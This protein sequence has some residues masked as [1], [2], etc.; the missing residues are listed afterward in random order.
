M[1]NYNLGRDIQEMK[2]ALKRIESV[3]GTGRS[4]QG[5]DSQTCVIRNVD[6][7]IDIHNVRTE[8][9]KICADIKVWVSASNPFPGGSDFNWERSWDNVCVRIDSG[10][11]ELFS[12]GVGPANVKIEACY[13]N[14]N[15]CI[16]LRVS[17][18]GISKSWKECRGVGVVAGAQSK[19]E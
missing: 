5:P 14:G 13:E 16:K 1:D 9:D 7:G 10:C 4:A 17:V 15:F 12:G 19:C 6:G 3:L 8:G 18:F 11:Y 2:E